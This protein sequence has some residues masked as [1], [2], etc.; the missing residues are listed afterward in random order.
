[1][2]DRRWLVNFDPEYFKKKSELG[3]SSHSVQAFREAF[4]ANHWGGD[5][6]S[7]PGSGGEQTAE[8]ATGI[9]ALCKRL[10]VR[11]LLDLPCGD[12]SWM[13]KLQFDGVSYIGGDLLPEIVQ[14]NRKVHGAHDR[15]FLELDLT[16]SELPAA[17]LLLCRDC[18]V[19]LSNRDVSSALQNIARSGIEWLLATTFPS[20]PTNIDIVTGDWRPIDL[21]KT[22]FSL[23]PPV[24]MLSE[25]CTEQNGAFA[26]KSLGLWPVAVLTNHDKN[27]S[28]LDGQRIR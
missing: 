11:R 14:Q 9:P 17:D 10:N 22:P 25:R 15:T 21:T 2:T 19:H 28:R 13:S 12:F 27:P 5:S 26:D 8:I 4:H 3:H 18:L 6:R 24:E 7:G 1:M 23:P 20:E 16:T